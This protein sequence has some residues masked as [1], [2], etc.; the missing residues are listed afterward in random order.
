MKVTVQLHGAFKQLGDQIELTLAYG[1]RVADLQELFMK[2]VEK[3][4]P[5]LYKQ[6][7]LRASR[8]CD[9]TRILRASQPLNDGQRLIILP[10]VSGG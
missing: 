8:F 3:C 9:D 4:N 2:T 10:P 6:G 5:E 1:T 7:W